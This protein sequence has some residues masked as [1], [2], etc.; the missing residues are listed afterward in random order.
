MIEL[1]SALGWALSSLIVVACSAIFYSTLLFFA[2]RKVNPEVLKRH[3]DVA[4]FAFSVI[5]ILYSVLL[6]F[7]VVNAQNRYDSLLQTVNEE[8][9]CLGCLYRDSGL[10]SP[11]ERDG[12]R[13]AIVDYIKYA[14]DEEWS[15]LSRAR[16]IPSLRKSAT[17]DLWSQIYSVMP[18]TEK[19]N[20][21]YAE[22]IKKMNEFATARLK[23]QLN[24]NQHISPMMWAL[25]LVGA[26]ITIGFIFFFSMDS[27]YAHMLLIATLSGYINFLLF[28]I[29][30]LDHIFNGPLGLKPETLLDLLNVFKIWTQ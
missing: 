16:K 8:A 19:E 27:L 22:A 10:F 4:G 14:T 9:D 28:L 25:L 15:A 23:R 21:W 18:T 26:A 3:H 20:I 30:C 24:F 29:Y 5:G 6:G 7:V 1:T 11:P 17:K 13:G 12:I 2:R